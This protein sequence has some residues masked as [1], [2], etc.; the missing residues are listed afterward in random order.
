MD[1]TDTRYLSYTVDRFSDAARIWAAACATNGAMAP[2]HVAD[3]CTE[4][5]LAYLQDGRPAARWDGEDLIDPLDLDV[6]ARRGTRRA[7]VEHESY[8]HLRRDGL[9][10]HAGPAPRGLAVERRGGR[11]VALVWDTG[12]SHVIR[13]RPISGERDR[14]WCVEIEADAAVVATSPRVGAFLGAAWSYRDGD[15]ETARILEIASWD[16]HD[17]AW[18]EARCAEQTERIAHRGAPMPHAV[19]AAVTMTLD[20]DDGE[21][22]HV[23]RGTVRRVAPGGKRVLV[24][25]IGDVRPRRSWYVDASELRPAGAIGAPGVQ[26]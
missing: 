13:L 22:P 4:Q 18:L 9:L 3:V 10:D 15:E 21:G 25:W 20:Y 12:G 16:G 19:G 26:P 17:E 24:D 1:T 14:A 23:Y 7:D 2:D 11:A 6:G 8:A 5:W